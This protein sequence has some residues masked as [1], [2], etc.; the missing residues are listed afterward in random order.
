VATKVSLPS[1]STGKI[2]ILFFKFSHPGHNKKKRKNILLSSL[3]NFGGGVL[4]ANC[5]CHWLPEVR[6]GKVKLLFEY[7]FFCVFKPSV[8]LV[9]QILGSE[10]CYVVY[11]QRKW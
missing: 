11:F 7:F 9:G 10:M 3:L 5:F 1:I 6:E 8:S 2:M 4:I